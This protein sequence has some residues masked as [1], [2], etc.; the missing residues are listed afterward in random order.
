MLLMP[1]GGGGGISEER[2][3]AFNFLGQQSNVGQWMVWGSRSCASIP[4]SCYAHS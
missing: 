1:R 3:G 2:D 4:C